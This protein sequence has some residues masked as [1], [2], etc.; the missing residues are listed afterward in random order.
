MSLRA[1]GIH[2]FNSPLPLALKQKKKFEN[3]LKQVFFQ[4]TKEKEYI[5]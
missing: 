5:S 3:F 4:K 2:P 1:R